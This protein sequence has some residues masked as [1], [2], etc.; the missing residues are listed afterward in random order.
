M[1]ADDS[2]ILFNSFF[3]ERGLNNF[4]EGERGAVTQKNLYLCDMIP[5]HLP[6]LN[7]PAC[8]A[9]VRR[10]NGVWKIFDPLRRK[11]VALTPEEWVR[12]HFVALLASKGYS[13]HRMANEVSL[14]L[15]GTLRRCD[16]VVFDNYMRPA[17]IIEYKAP[18]VPITERVFGQAGR[19]NL[20][21]GAKWLIVSNGM[22]T[23]CCTCNDDGTH[24]FSN[25]IPTYEQ[26][27]CLI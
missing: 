27:C 5:S 9:P 3:V 1:I 4:W 22:H 21:M 18:G 11:F 17:I 8:P 12:Q 16:T 6:K 20:V 2:V 25:E 19:Y 10:D 15:N 14:R 13:P 24:V 26:V 23:Y 7:L